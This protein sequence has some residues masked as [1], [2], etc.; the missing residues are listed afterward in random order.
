[1]TN[2]ISPQCFK[3]A[4]DIMRTMRR[5]AFQ[6]TAEIHSCGYHEDEWEF[7]GHSLM[8]AVHTDEGDVVCYCVDNQ[9]LTDYAQARN[10]LAQTM[11]VI[12]DE[13]G[14]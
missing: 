3:I 1:M 14:S 6:Q 12:L 5:E 10:E 8:V 2:T 11:E 9:P 13:V 4:E 7:E